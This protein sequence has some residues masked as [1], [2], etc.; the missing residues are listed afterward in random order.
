MAE[1]PRRDVEGNA[2][3]T[4]PI[5]AAPTFQSTLQVPDDGDPAQATAPGTP[6]ELATV[7]EIAQTVLDNTKALETWL[8]STCF[9]ASDNN[10]LAPATFDP[11]II[12]RMWSRPSGFADG[13]AIKIDDSIDWRDRDVFVLFKELGGSG[14]GR[15]EGGAHLQNSATVEHAWGYLGTGGLDAAASD[16]AVTGNPPIIEAGKF[17]VRVIPPDVRLYANA[18]T[19]HLWLFNN[20][21]AAVYV[22]LWIFATG[23][24]TTGDGGSASADGS[25]TIVGG[26]S[27][28]S[29]TNG[30]VLAH[31]SGSWAST[32]AGTAGQPLLSNGAG[33]PAYGAQTVP[34][35]QRALDTAAAA[36]SVCAVLSH[37][38]SSGTA[39]SG[40]GA[41]CEFRTTNA[42]NDL[43][44]IAA[45]DAVATVTTADAEVGVLDVWLAN[46][47]GAIDTRALRIGTTT[48]STY[49]G[50][51]WVPLFARTGG[52]WIYGSSDASNGG[53]AVLLAPGSGAGIYLRRGATNHLFINSAGSLVVGTTANTTAIQGTSVTLA[54]TSGLQIGTAAV[55]TV[56]VGG[57]RIPERTVSTNT[58][59]DSQDEVVFVI[60]SGGTVTLTLPAGASG[61]VLVIQRIAG[62]ADVIVQRAGADTI[63]AG[64][65]SGLT[66]WTI[67][68]SARHGLIYRSSAS[69]WVAEA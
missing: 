32:G 24:T 65:S 4:H 34:L 67:S 5:N 22:E 48:L 29:G 27:L 19:G 30:G 17:C 59:L 53:N 46:G 14:C 52:E 57:A 31:A 6:P 26:G 18:D 64:G 66:S 54:G 60:T 11:R 33:A 40:I 20:S 10:A 25:T 9:P 15:D 42:A 13:S 23:K 2:T 62:T 37:E 28:P 38:L 45:I 69:E 50:A 63:R 7:E 39:A 68:D 49:T 58:T 47:A 1:R 36:P 12:T 43:A 51:A 61:R 35:T 41:R 21:G 8:A 56:Y 44:P 3:V 16:P 55:V